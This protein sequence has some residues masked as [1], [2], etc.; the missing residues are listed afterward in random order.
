MAASPLTACVGRMFARP[1]DASRQV[2]SRS[3][4]DI[5]KE[6]QRRSIER[7]FETYFDWV[8]ETLTSEDAPFIQIVAVVLG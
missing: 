7:V 1:Q 2:R 4:R 8:D 6:R 5:E 3:R